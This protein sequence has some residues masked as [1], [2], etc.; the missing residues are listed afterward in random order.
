MRHPPVIRAFLQ[1]GK[2]TIALYDNSTYPA[3]TFG[4]KKFCLTNRQC[5][6]STSRQGY[7]SFVPLK[8]GKVKTTN[9]VL[10]APMS[11]ISDLPFRAQA[12]G[13]GAG[14]VVCEMIASSELVKERPEPL[15]R[16]KRLSGSPFVIQLAG[17][18]AKWMAEGARY[19]ESL[20]ADIIDINMGCPAKHVT[21][22]QSGSALMRNPDHALEL[23]EAVIGAASVP[24]TLKMRLGW[25]HAELNAPEIAR[26]AEQ[27]GVQMVTIHGRTRCQFFNGRADWAAISAVKKVVSIP[28]IANGDI[29][30]VADAAEVLRLSQA[31][32]VMIG[33]GACGAP[34]FP[35]RVAKYLET[36]RDPGNPPL[37][38]QKACVEEHYDAMLIHYGKE[39]GGKN[40]RKHL[41]WYAEQTVQNKDELAHWRRRFCAD[42]NPQDVKQAIGAFYEQQ[43][44]KAA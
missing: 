21:K 41:S 3:Q 31:D 14:L 17:R 9:C 18:E 13:F 39:L 36:G 27:V 5:K 35:G 11:G 25:D 8:I 4:I 37:E 29:R 16:A 40:A 1:C 30:T 22:G 43:L 20:G 15:R 23:I 24:V 44:E 42:Q 34:W 12:D 2:Q 7:Y 28:V 19:A 33:R 38:L 32:G 26:R 10:L 6:F